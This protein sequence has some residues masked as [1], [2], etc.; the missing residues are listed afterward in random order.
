MTSFSDRQRVRVT[1]GADAGKT[2]TVERITEANGREAWVRLNEP[3]AF[4]TFHDYRSQNVLLPAS[5]CE[6]IG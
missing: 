4:P 1:R 3:P 6:P 2:G 5:D